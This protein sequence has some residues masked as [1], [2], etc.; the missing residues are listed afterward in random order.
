MNQAARCSLEY[1]LLLSTP[2]HLLPVLLAPHC[3]GA[4]VGEAATR[5]AAAEALLIAA[6]SMAG[7]SDSDTLRQ[8]VVAMDGVLAGGCLD[9]NEVVVL[10]LGRAWPVHTLRQLVVARGGLLA[11]KKNAKVAADRLCHLPMN[12]S[13]HPAPLQW[14]P[15]SAPTPCHATERH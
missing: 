4:A 2:P 13:L 12:H 8:L 6:D 5:A 10:L 14:A 7:A 11:D 9:W 1:P 3:S 15:P